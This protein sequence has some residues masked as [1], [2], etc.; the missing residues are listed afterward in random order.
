MKLTS[1]LFVPLL[2]TCALAAE[3][4]VELTVK[5]H[6]K[7]ARPS[8]PVTS[9]VPLPRG[10]VKESSEL[11]LSSG[12]KAVPCQFNTVTR[13]PDGSV[14]WTEL[15]FQADLPAGGEC[16]YRL[17][18]G[19][20]K[21]PANAVKVE[22]VGGAFKI[23]TGTIVFTVPKKKGNI[24]GEIRSGGKLLATGQGVRIL[25]ARDGQEG[26]VFSTLNGNVE[27][28]EVERSG[29]AMA[30]VCLV[31]T[32]ASAKGGAYLDVAK[33]RK[34]YSQTEGGWFKVR[35]RLHAYAGK[36]F[37]YAVVSL[38]HAGPMD[39]SSDAY[40]KSAALELAPAEAL[41]SAGAEG[42]SGAVQGKGFRLLQYLGAGRG[43]YSMKFSRKAPTPYFR[44]LIDGVEKKKGSR[45]V[46]SVIAAGAAG[47][48]CVGVR[49][50]Y[51]YAPTA[52]TVRENS[53]SVGLLPDDPEQD[54][55]KLQGGRQ[56]SHEVLLDFSADP[57]KN[58]AAFQ[59][60]RLLAMAAPAWY[61]DLEVFGMIAEEEKDLSR[62]PAGQRAAIR[63]WYEVQR[64]HVT[65]KRSVLNAFHPGWLDY[66]DLHWRPGWSNG[67]YDWTLGMLLGF[68][69]TGK[70]EFFE[71]ADAFAWHRFDVA[72]NH[73]AEFG[74]VDA[75]YRWSRALTYYE[76]DDHRTTGK[77]P[78]Q[79]HS[80]NRGIAYYG[81]LTGNEMARETAIF[82]GKGIRNYF[83]GSVDDGKWRGNW[84]D[85]GK[86]YSSVGQEQR[87]EGWSI[88]NLLG[89]YEASGEE[90]WKTYAVNLFKATMLDYNR[91]DAW[92]GKGMGAGALMFGYVLSPSCR[93][94]YYSR[95]ADVL[96]G[97][98]YLVD[99]GVLN[100]QYG[101]LKIGEKGAGGDPKTVFMYGKKPEAAY[102]IHY[103]NPLAYLYMRT[104]DEKYLKTA[105]L[106][107]R[108]MV[109]VYGRKRGVRPGHDTKTGGWIGR[110]NHIYLYM[111]K[112]LARGVKF[113]ESSK[114]R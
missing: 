92:K 72:Q 105:R 86:P 68:L 30:R 100:K 34:K 23:D 40:F 69:R 24:I 75:R 54:S 20:P 76:K 25:G 2:M 35:V 98:K 61:A 53:V 93:A 39:D 32:L 12:G 31:A 22:E 113:P 4:P 47:K 70:R 65:G 90:K 3:L 50:F 38:T 33:S 87:A 106:V 15:N 21:S 73:S 109:R 99:E 102:H 28:V 13:W 88:E 46:G 59:A 71:A 26:L 104:G 64:S 78:K 95:D 16:K 63:T 96:A 114:K 84:R 81:L 107:F 49:R 56:R 37:I 14:R 79:T 9:G 36:P 66:G 101:I 57:A 108:N 17:T 6:G 110:F 112:Q 43:N 103:V 18:K 82:N 94:D 74:K 111:E 27:K 55:H 45:A 11:S 10:A 52:I 8:W 91:K 51:E 77:G 62:Y 83:K 85:G 67:H 60:P 29:P 1:A 58:L 7:V 5:E 97:I 48:V 80:W 41:Q 89:C 19:T 42:V 44:V